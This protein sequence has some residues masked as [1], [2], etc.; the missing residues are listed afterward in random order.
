MAL[1]RVWHVQRRTIVL[2]QV[3]PVDLLARPEPDLPLAELACN[4]G[5]RRLL[6]W[7]LAL[8][9]RDELPERF[10]RLRERQPPIQSATY[11]MIWLELKF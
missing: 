3:V 7:V 5:E 1:L 6:C 10:A 8:A 9:L 4:L 11:S 2:A